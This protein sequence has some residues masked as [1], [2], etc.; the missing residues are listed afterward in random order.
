MPKV[1]KTN[2]VEMRHQP[3]TPMQIKRS[4]TLYEQGHAIARI[5]RKPNL[6]RETIRRSL[7]A[8]WMKLRLRSGRTG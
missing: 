6:P 2:N 8:S 3:L 4:A 7:Q 1:L 5:A